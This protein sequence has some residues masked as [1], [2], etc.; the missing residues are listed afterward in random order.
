L[1]A[2]LFFPDPKEAN[3]EKDHGRLC[4][5]RIARLSVDPEE[6]GLCGCWQIIAVERQREELCGKSPKKTCEVSYYATSIHHGQRGNRELLTIIR[7]HFGSIENGSH[8][9]RD[10]TYRED[11]CRISKNGAQP[12][13]T[14][15]NLAIG[16]YGLQKA[17]D[18]TKVEFS[19][20]C[21]RMTF[22]NA[23]NLIRGK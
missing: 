15:R 22:S 20:W 4:C 18:K 9:R 8:H 5:W 10:V 11:G 16:I 1:P 12:M 7:D 21:R 19:S 6:I 3:W 13:A 17:A 23:L 14:L 2:S